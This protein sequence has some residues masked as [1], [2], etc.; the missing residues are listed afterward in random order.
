MLSMWLFINKE[1]RPVI[2]QQYHIHRVNSFQ[3]HHQ[4]SW[5]S[6]EIDYEF[7]KYKLIF[8][9]KA[10]SQQTGAYWYCFS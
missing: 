7:E 10:T 8:Q 5:N 9:Y 1:L 4:F 3:P 2:T 6:V